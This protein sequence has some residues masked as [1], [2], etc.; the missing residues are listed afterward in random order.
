M[1]STANDTTTS[2][3]TVETA[4]PI[5]ASVEALSPRIQARLDM[6]NE[7]I[8]ETNPFRENS[9][10]AEDRAIVAAKDAGA[11]D[12]AKAEGDAIIEAAK[13]KAAAILEK[14]KEAAKAKKADVLAPYMAEAEKAAAA[15]NVN[16][17]EASKAEKLLA[18]YKDGLSVALAKENLTLADVEHFL[19]DETPKKGARVSFGTKVEKDYDPAAVRT[20]AK[21]NGVEVS[22]KGRFSDDVLSAYRA[23]NATA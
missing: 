1:T 23:A 4:K 22:E 12:A 7:Q 9:L 15:S 19:V 18:A 8:I 6:V 16:P 5:I 21:E 13:V 11:F 17:I 2:T 3:D 10:S 20:W 14:A